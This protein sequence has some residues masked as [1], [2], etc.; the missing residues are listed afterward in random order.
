[1]ARQRAR[2]DPDGV[3]GG[4]D[5][6]GGDHRRRR[7]RLRAVRA[8]ARRE[9][10]AAASRAALQRR[11]R[12][13][14]DRRAARRA[15][16]ARRPRAHRRGDHAAVR[17]AQA[18]LAPATRAGGLGAHA[19][20]RR[21][22]RLGRRAPRR[23]RFAER[24]WALESG[25]YELETPTTRRDLCAAAGMRRAC[26]A[27]SATPAGDRRDHAMSSPR[28]PASR[29]HPGRRGHGRPRLL[30]VRRRTR[31]ARR[32]ARQARR[33][34]DVLACSDRP[35]LDARLYLDAHPSPG[36]VAAER[37][38]GERRLGRAL[39]PARARG[40]ARSTCWTPRRRRPPPGPRAS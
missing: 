7:R 32:S 36:P 2:A 24:N 21:L 16:G 14:R 30:G 6:R 34:V 39:V 33:S 1:M 31:R 27:R 3:C 17:R 4:V 35:L 22:V 20:H 15:G 25:L 13:R 26:S 40:G 8:R 5:R 10:L 19:A 37:L 12:P 18:A 29:R 38:H 9:R 28:A 23:R 11:P